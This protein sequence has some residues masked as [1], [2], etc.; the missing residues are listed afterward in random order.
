[1]R[2]VTYLYKFQTSQ[3]IAMIRTTQMIQITQTTEVI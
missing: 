2:I 1:M 3:M